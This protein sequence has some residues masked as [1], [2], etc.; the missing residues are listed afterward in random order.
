M[1]TFLHDHKINFTHCKFPDHHHFT[2]RDIQNINEQFDQLTSKRK[3]MLTTEK[4]Y[5]RIENRIQEL[6]FLGIETS[7]LSEQEAFDTIIKNHI[8]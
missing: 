4:D 8:Q 3:L 6:S 5:V 7:F 2:N 1:L